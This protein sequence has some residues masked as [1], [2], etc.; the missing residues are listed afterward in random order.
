MDKIPSKYLAGGRI[1]VVFSFIPLLIII[2]YRGSVIDHASGYSLVIF[3][4]VFLD[5]MYLY[6]VLYLYIF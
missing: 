1:I 6:Y 4:L 5:L 2:W 3:F